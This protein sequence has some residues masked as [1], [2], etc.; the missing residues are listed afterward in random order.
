MSET[1]SRR[2]QNELTKADAMKK[3]IREQRRK[4][5]YDNIKRLQI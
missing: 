3:K 5:N 1:I 2:V 4:L